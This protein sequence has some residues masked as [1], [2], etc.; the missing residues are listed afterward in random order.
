MVEEVGPVSAALTVFPK[1]CTEAK[2]VLGGCIVH[3]KEVAAHQTIVWTSCARV[4]SDVML[5]VT[6]TVRI[7]LSTET[8][9]QLLDVV[10]GDCF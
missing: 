5:F 4:K 1:E 10:I 6:S 2:Q 7:P 3:P 8:A 9:N